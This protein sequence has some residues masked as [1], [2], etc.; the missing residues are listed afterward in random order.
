MPYSPGVSPEEFLKAHLAAHPEDASTLGIAGHADRLPSFEPVVFTGPTDDLDRDAAARASLGFTRPGIESS[1]EPA[2]LPNALLQHAALHAT[3]DDDWRAIAKRAS[4]VPAFLDAHA[5]RLRRG[6]VD[7]DVAKVFAERVM[8]NAAEAIA[9]LASTAAAKKCAPEVVTLV[10][11]AT[12]AAADAY[13]AF[14]AHA[15]SERSTRIDVVLGEEETALRLRDVMGVDTPADDLVAEAR[16]ELARLRPKVDRDT[17]M[18]VLAPRPA[19]LDEALA[20]YRRWLL[21]ATNFIRDRELVPVPPS[22]ALA[23]EPLPGGIADG[24]S[25]T[26]W[27]APL[28][29]P[30]G[31]GHLL[32]ATD[33][34]AHVAVSM[35]NLAVHEG[36]PGHYLQ[37]AW[38][39]R[40]ARPEHACRWLGVADDVAF[41][42]GYF[43]TMLAVEG[44]AVYMEQLLRRHGFYDTPEELLFFD[45]CDII[46]AMRVV[47]DLDLQRG[48]MTSDE[49]TRFVAETTNMPEGWAR[50]QVVRAKRLPLQGLTYRVGAREIERVR[51]SFRGDDLEFHAKLLELGPVPPSRAFEVLCAVS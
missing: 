10:S 43:G 41:A 14:A 30:K 50:T 13:R 25:V 49:A 11:E 1:L 47:L 29:D 16:D 38:W 44:W 5:E 15:A 22:L 39:Q 28:F 51:K 23:L 6:A 32:Y 19:T 26:N 2:A 4:K 3:S 8:P 46:R 24:G 42:W 27:P 45:F 36:I 21:E 34:S 9:S 40:H 7:A 20:G 48:R 35:K 33:P 37:S 18:K 17:L 31:K 12:T